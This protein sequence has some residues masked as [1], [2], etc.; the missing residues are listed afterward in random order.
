MTLD[1]A[2]K[3]A[4]AQGLNQLHPRWWRRQIDDGRVTARKGAVTYVER[5]HAERIIELAK[6][7]AEYPMVGYSLIDAGKMR[8]GMPEAAT[9]VA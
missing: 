3:L 4:A 6:L 7:G 1:A 5:A 2:A 9:H 8:E